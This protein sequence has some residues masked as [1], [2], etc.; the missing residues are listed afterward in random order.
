MKNQLI[1]ALV[2]AVILFIWQFLSWGMQL[3]H[4]DKMMYTPNQDAILSALEGQGLEEG[5][6]YFLPT[7]PQEDYSDETKM[8][9]YMDTYT[10]KPWATISYH[11]SL[12]NKYM[13]NLIRG[14]LVD[15]VALFI[16][17]WLLGKINGLDLQTAVLASLGISMISYLTVP[18]TNHI[19]FEGSAIGHLIDAIVPW[20]IIGAWLGWFLTRK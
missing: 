17:V 13:Q 1:G 18:Y 2:G 15:F 7:I 14:F 5:V 19:W 10:G 11:N 6:T 16:L 12:E 20:A 4:A 3:V 8:Q 9:A